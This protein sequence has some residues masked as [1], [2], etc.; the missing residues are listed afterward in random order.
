MVKSSA[1][2]QPPLKPSNLHLPLKNFLKNNYY[3]IFVYDYVIKNDSKILS[4]LHLWAY[5]FE[6]EVEK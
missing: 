5:N 4:N 3:V 6:A 2:R 1:E